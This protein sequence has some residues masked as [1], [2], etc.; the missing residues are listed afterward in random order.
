MKKLFKARMIGLIWASFGLGVNVFAQDKAEY[1]ER[2]VIVKLKNNALSS[3]ARAIQASLNATVLQKFTLIDA[4]L[5]AISGLDVEEAANRFRNDPRIEYIEPNYIVSLVSPAP[6]VFP[7]DPRFSS[8]W[9]LHNTGQTGGKPDADID[10][11]EAWSIETGKQV[12][13]GVIDSGVDW[14]HEDLAANIWTNPGEIP[15][16]NL[17]D[18]K[19]N[20]IDDVRGWDFVNNDN[21]PM[22][23]NGHGSHVS[24]TIAAI[25]NNGKGVVGV[26]WSARIMPLKFLDASGR[27]STANAILA[28]EYATKTGARLTSNSWGGGSFSQAL[29]DAIDASG[30]A[31]LLFIAAAGNEGRDT[32]VFPHYP[33]SYDL[34]NIIAVAAT[35]HNDQLGQCSF[36]NWGATSVD[37]GAPGDNILSS[38]PGN[39]YSTLCGTSMATPHVS[40]VASLIWSLAPGLPPLEVKNVIISSVDPVPAL[41]GR[42]VSGGRLNAHQALLIANPDSIAPAPVKD[43]AA[44]APGSNS[45]T[46][47]WT[48]TGDDTTTGTAARYDIR[49]STSPITASNFDSA[50]VATNAPSPQPAG[51]TETFTVKG[52]DFNTIYYLALRVIDEQGNAAAIS[53]V[54]SDSTLGIPAIAISPDSVIEH[55]FTGEKRAQPLTISNVGEGTLDFVLPDFVGQAA[56]RVVSAERDRLRLQILPQKPFSVSAS[57]P[58]REGSDQAPPSGPANSFPLLQRILSQTASNNIVFFDDVEKGVNGWTTQL[59]DGATDNL[60]HQTTR[61]FNS[62]T[63]SWW[64]GI[65]SQGNYATGRRI[66]TA[67]VSPAINL[68]SFSAPVTLQFFENYNTERGF[69]FCMVDVSTDGGASWTPLRGGIGT[70]PSGSS[71]GWIMTTLDLSQFVDK[72]IHIRF[73]FD[74][75]DASGNAFPGWFFD[76]VLV[77]AAGVPWLS[78]N[79]AEGSVPADSSMNIAFTFDATGLFGG[80]YDAEVAI[81]SNDPDHP[82]T[83]VA[84]QLHVTGAPDISVSQDTLNFGTVFNGFL[85]EDSLIVSNIGTDLLTVTNV[86]T[87]HPNYTVDTTA[88]N[89]DPGESRG[90]I[91]R[92]APGSIGAIAGTLTIVSNDVDEESLRVALRAESIEPP[93]ASVSPT[94]LSDTLFTGQMATHSLTISNTGGSDLVWKIEI[95]ENLAL[96]SAPPEVDMTGWSQSLE[97]ASGR[98]DEAKINLSNLSSQSA[99]KPSALAKAPRV[100]LLTSQGGAST[101]EAALIST[102]LFT[103][104]EIDILDSPFTL[105]LADLLPYDAVL[106]WVNV[107]FSNP[108]Q[109][110][111]VLKEYVDAGGGVVLA[112]Y[113]LSQSWAIQGG[114]LNGNYS[115]FL[116]APQQSVSGTLD[117]SSIT[118]PGHRIFAGIS[119]NPTYWFNFNYSNP[120]LNAGGKLLARDTAGNRV[121]AE[122][123]SGGVV[124]IVVYPGLLDQANAETKRL[125]AN[126]LYYVASPALNWVSVDTT[127]GIVPAGSSFGVTVKFDATDLAGGNRE[128]QLL[129]KSNDPANTEIAVPARLRVIGAPDIAVEQDTLDFGRTFVGVKDS[130]TMVVKNRGAADLIITSAATQPSQFEVTPRIVGID[131]GEEKRLIVIFKPD[132]TAIFQGTLTLICNDPDEDTLAVALL[133]EGLLPPSIAVAPTSLSDTLVTGQTSSHTLSISNTGGSELAWE[134]EITQDLSLSSTPADVDMTSWSLSKEPAAGKISAAE[135]SAPAASLNPGATTVSLSAP[136]VLLL[137]TSGNASIVETV[138]I[139]TGLFTTADIDVREFPVSISLSDLLPYDAVLV[140]VNQ[141]FNNPQQIGDVLKQYVDAG[142]GVILA[143]YSLSQSWAIQGG[144]LNGNYSPFLPGVEQSVSGVLDLSSVAVPGHRIFAGIN[145]NP[146]YWFNFNYSNPTLNAGGKLLA[147]DT[148]GNRVVAENPSGKVVGIVIYPGALDLANAATKQMFANALYYVASPAPDWVRVD[149]TSGVVAP[150]SSFGVTV[151]FDATGL[152]SGNF[153]AEILVKNNDPANRKISVPAHLHAIGAP[154]IAVEQDTLDFGEVFAAVVDSLAFVVKNIGTEDLIILNAQAQPAAYTVS[155]AVASI[156]PG[157]TEE[158]LVTFSPP[159]IGSFPGTLTFTSN[160]PDEATFT[161]VLIGEGVEPPQMSVSPASLQF[162]VSAGDT[163]TAVMTIANNGGSRLNFNIRDEEQPF[164]ARANNRKLFW[165]LEQDFFPDTLFHSNLDGSQIK[166]LISSSNII[167]IEVDEKIGRIYWVDFEERSIK[168]SRLDG[169]DVRSVLAGLS[170]P[171]DVALDPD[172]NKMYWT[173]FNGNTINRANLDGTGLEIIIQGSL[174]NSST[175]SSRPDAGEEFQDGSEVGALLLNRP[176]GIALDLTHGKVYWTEQSGDRIGRANLD[177]GAAEIIISSGID[178]PRGI[179]V[180]AAGGKIYFVDSFNDQIKRANLDGTGVQTLL[181]FSSSDNTLDLEL[182]INEKK[183]Y[184][185]SNVVDQIQRANLDGSNAEVVITRLLPGFDGPTGLAIS[186]QGGWLSQ[187]PTDGSVPPDSSAEITVTVDTRDLIAGRY[188][189]LIFVDGNDPANPKDSV[190]V[191]LQVIGEP[192]IAISDS[193][194]D[195]G[196]VFVGA[197]VSKPL[198]VSNIGTDSLIVHSLVV[199]PSEFQVNLNSFV[200]PARQSR[201]VLVTFAPSDTGEVA[202]TLAITSND[203]QQPEIT[204]RLQGEGL[205]PPDIAVAP[206]SLSEELPSGGRSAQTLTIRNSDP[207]GSALIFAITVEAGQDSLL[208]ISAP[209]AGAVNQEA[210]Q[211]PNNGKAP[212]GNANAVKWM[213]AASVS[214]LAL[215]DSSGTVPPGDSVEVNVFFDAAGLKGGDFQTRLV[216]SSNDPDE[217]K[218]FVPVHLQVTDAPNIVI[219][220]TLL[221]FGRVFIGAT[222]H[223]TLRIANNG[224]EVLTV[225]DIASDHP[226]FSA[227]VR[228]FTIAPGTERT[229]DV[230]FAPA[231]TGNRRALL[232]ITSNDPDD[233]VVTVRLAGEGVEPPDISATPGVFSFFVMP[234]DCTAAVLKL[235]NSGASPLTFKIRD[236]EEKISALANGQK[237]YWSEFFSFVPDTLHRSNLD[238]TGIETIFTNTGEL[239]GIAVDDGAGRIYWADDLE[240]T[241]RTSKLDGTDARVLVSGLAGPNDVALDLSAG[242]IYWTDFFANTISRANLDGKNLE[243]IVKGNSISPQSSPKSARS[244]K[245]ASEVRSE[246]ESTALFTPWGIALDLVHGKLYWTEQDSDRIGR[247]NLD[248]T[249]QETIIDV[250]QGLFGPRGIKVDASAGKIYIVDS[251]NNAIK[252]ANLDGTGIQTIL[253]FQ[254]E[255]NPLDIELDLNGQQLYWSDNILDRIQRANFDGSNVTTIIHQP[256]LDIEGVYGVGLA[257]GTGWLS[258]APSEG[259]IP[260]GESKDITLAVDASSL[261][262]RDYQAT[263]FIE[264]NDPDESLITIPVSLTVGEAQVIL[265]IA[266][267]LEAVA[268]DTADVPVFLTLGDTSLAVAALNAALKA[269]DQTLSFAGFTVGPIIS[270]PRFGVHNPAPDSVRFAYANFGGDPITQSGLLVTLHFAVDSAAE[271]GKTTFLTFGELSAGNPNGQPLVIN[272]RN[273]Q[274]TVIKFVSIAGGVK[275][276]SPTGGGNPSKLVADLTARLSQNGVLVQEKRTNTSGDYQLQNIIP[277]RGYQVRLVRESGGVGPAITAIDALIAFNSVA[278]PNLINGCQRLAADVNGDTILTAQ[279]ATLIFDRYLGLIAKFPV[280]DWRTFPASFDIEVRTPAWKIVPNAISYPN[281]KSNQNGQNY[282]AVVKGDVDLS[283][284]AATPDK[285]LSAPGQ[286]LAPARFGSLADRSAAP[287]QFTVA[288]TEIAPVAEVVRMQIRMEGLGIARGVYALGGEVEYKASSLAITAVRWGNVVPSEGFKIDYHLLPKASTSP[289]QKSESTSEALGGRLRFGGFSVSS[290]AIRETGMLLEIEAKVIGELT[291]GSSLPVRLVEISAAIGSQSGSGLAKGMNSAAMA[292]ESAAVEVVDGAIVIEKIPTE[293]ALEPNYPNPFNPATKI[294]YQLPE[295]SVVSLYV[296]NAL[297]QKVRTLV[298]DQPQAAGFKKIEWDGRDDA[299]VPTASGVYFYM[300]RAKSPSREFSKT[301]KMLLVR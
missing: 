14:L 16:N 254:S 154:D 149:T 29:R 26:S 240:G 290:Q 175:T 145:T 222:A 233:P 300:L 88:F 4:E 167:G 91:V 46:L 37:L 212:T 257:L 64:C 207:N 301:R 80:V 291:P 147:R 11:P 70:A 210:L 221:N 134:I 22:D 249:A 139:S 289:E 41:A 234:G 7:V 248:G 217:A 118:V 63:R 245:K 163:A 69:D 193:I 116:P 94:S 2:Q 269:S 197:T 42:M 101:A 50:A 92:L 155:P 294:R 241:I 225:N 208:A 162:T 120:T 99:S 105:S 182:D 280:D 48:A 156:D 194:L 282:L 180:D 169:S 58:R 43:L 40:G 268:G 178:G 33:S 130:L 238:G 244:D 173:D 272:G 126:A 25:G 266:D 79:P 38:T 160:D 235:S 24:G 81:L 18:D 17:D 36:S 102:G 83:L 59:Y 19:N 103:G 97:P 198:I 131:P 176:W 125:F 214:W 96:S 60:W 117:L 45:I 288:T 256:A 82:D 35:D 206:D 279:D 213:T 253:S 209:R 203:P 104:T 133:G 202:G 123:P 298:P 54:V 170:G 32:D 287:I 100:L 264:S 263:I 219:A 140:W 15:N 73:Y 157:E 27:G 95:A 76:D 171:V 275:Y 211:Q 110:G 296:F 6:T 77:T 20:Y 299:G 61:A 57:L 187:A 261:E 183:F 184:W 3:E 200:V 195:Y 205:T 1:L 85:Y 181:S 274:T 152:A 53:N 138:L 111:D 148:A 5:W 71:G 185:T 281:L 52:L 262:E 72:A 89:L 243:V 86:F 84:A 75:R 129:V 49:Y 74:T 191:S 267:T 250:G 229:V 215:S 114:I 34:D 23:D 228:T 231:Q 158:F 293:Y 230:S 98:V 44:I 112:T 67:V 161:V 216:I 159:S 270:G 223:D 255:A 135:F 236:E 62:P 47:A 121:V 56:V 286:E 271:H 168:S 109:I 172:R 8:L 192:K 224:S 87:N 113:S 106:V 247:S 186:S 122:N 285:S 292:F 237:L 227:S 128:A 78:V 246:E 39:T 189:A 10:A 201:M 276:C 204:V 190:Q 295:A 174:A 273:G 151:T 259:I 146:T 265:A 258:V 93:V 68:T 132:T 115:P 119:A 179:K 242:K 260:P 239:G 252:R 188:E 30:K 141:N 232:T 66:N 143:T 164:S 55:L 218:I 65:E 31:G 13:I 283:W 284:P 166:S 9:G 165:G 220:D 51:T 108:Q 107:N 251:F 196:Q 226:D 297:G 142:G 278:Q 127:S 21:N 137:T 277:G 12:V 144:I 124:G 177:G 153:D 136:R 28:I 150:G 90:V 199:D